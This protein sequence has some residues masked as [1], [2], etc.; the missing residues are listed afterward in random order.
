MTLD[1]RI[2]EASTRLRDVVALHNPAT[3]AS[4][5]GAEDM[6]ILDLIATLDLDVEV[7]T[8]DTGRLHDETHELIA[9]AVEKYQR[10]IRIMHPNSVELESFVENNGINA[11][12]DSVELRKRCCAIRKVAPLR[13]ALEGKRLWI[14]GLRR[15]QSVTRSDF[16][17]LAY[18]SDHG[19][20]KLNP[21][22]DWSTE[23]VFDYL[24]RFDVPSNRLHAR[25][26][27][28]IGCAP[29]TRAV[30]SGEDERSGRWWW[31]QAESRECGLHV[32]S[33]GR[34]VRSATTNAGVNT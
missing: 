12:Y 27:P 20:F 24:Q 10:S 29:C 17:L 30:K 16:A 18:D 1:T 21:L 13:H 6:V 26:Y 8:L 31:E 3:F 23:E 5:F 2:S 33:R 32:D 9:L 34:V 11:F 15:D 7:F 4:S 19:L 25:G 22:V 14:T 28:S